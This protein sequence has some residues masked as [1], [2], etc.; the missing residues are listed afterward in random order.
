M[1]I[2]RFRRRRIGAFLGNAITR[3]GMGITTLWKCFGFE[4]VEENSG[5]GSYGADGSPAFEFGGAG[6]GGEDSYL[7]ECGSGDLGFVGA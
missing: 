7:R 1:T 5:T 3:M 2:L 6:I 4:R